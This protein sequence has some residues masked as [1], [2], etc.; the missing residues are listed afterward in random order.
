LPINQHAMNF[1]G[2][3]VYHEFGGFEFDMRQRAPLIRDL[4]DKKIA[5]LRNHGS[6]V[7]GAM[8]G[9]AMVA[10]NQLEVAC[11]GQIA[12]LSAGADEIVLVSP[13]SQA[14]ALEQVRSLNAGRDDGGKDWKGMVRMADRMF[15]DYRN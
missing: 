9:G 7:C 3:I 13:E 11:Q 15:P 10:H 8:I 1:M 14:Y 6:L 2:N 12:A 4:G 5:L